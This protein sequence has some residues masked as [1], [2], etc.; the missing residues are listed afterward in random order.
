MKDSLSP[1][2]NYCVYNLYS[3]VLNKYY[4]GSSEDVDKRLDFHH[5]PTERRKFTVRGAPWIIVCTL[6]CDSREHALRLE[7][8]IKRMKSRDF[9]ERLIS[10]ESMQQ[11][12]INK[13]RAPDC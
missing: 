13:T 12:L 10:S 5:N 2:C 8:F 11:D 9:I 3:R 4:V 6:A 7:S 1:L